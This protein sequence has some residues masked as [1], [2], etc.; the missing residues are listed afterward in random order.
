MSGLTMRW[1]DPSEFNCNLDACRVIEI[2]IPMRDL[3]AVELSPFDRAL[4]RETAKDGN[5]AIAD[6]LLC[7]ETL[8][9]RIEDMHAK[10]RKP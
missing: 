4:F 1:E 7:L 6:N 3:V 10:A 5:A 8:V 2:R 9:R